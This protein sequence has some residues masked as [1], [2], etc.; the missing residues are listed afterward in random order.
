LH[1]ERTPENPIIMKHIHCSYHQIW[2]VFALLVI[3]LKINASGGTY[4]VLD[5]GAKPDGKSLNTEIIQDAIDKCSKNGGGMVVIPSGRYVTGTVVLK[6]N[7]CLRLEKGAIILGS[8]NPK[9][10]IRMKPAYIAYRTGTETRQLIYA[11]SQD[12]ISIEGEGTIDGQGA[13]FVPADMDGAGLTD[14]GITRPH[15]IQLIT[16]TN[17]KIE[18][19]FLTNSG[20]WMQHY[21][22]CDKLQVRGIRVKNFSNINN[23]GID[24]DG[25]HDVNISDCIIESADDGIC[26]KATSPRS[27]KNVVI[28]NCNVHSLSNAIKMGTET[29]GGFQNISITN[30][31]I[32]PVENNS[33]VYN[34]PDGSSAISL[35]IVDGGLL[36]NVNISN[37]SISE[38]VC[39][40][41][42]RLGNRARKY[43]PDAEV[44]PVGKIRNI[45]LSDIIAVSSHPT[46][47]SVVGI[48][49][50]DVENIVF[51]NVQLISKSK[52]TPED[53]KRVVP[54][55]NDYPTAGMHG[56][57]L[58]ASAFYVRHAKNIRFV[59]LQLIV[60]GE[61]VRPPFVLDDAKDVLIIHPNVLLPDT[62]VK[63]IQE[64]HCKNIRLIKN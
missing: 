22:A 51:D 19:V 8:T 23:D 46:T 34:D 40:I 37:I 48:P 41:F 42:I 29:T 57:I 11:E 53:A 63:L 44:P 61:N 47:S 20:A 31:S 32:S 13:A 49:G 45:T 59:N 21:L 62:T 4:N 18:G 24:I 15:L 16:C 56:D 38:T 1:K 43:K 10:Y 2:L 64:Q 35:M 9:D 27:C 7:V 39:P 14:A 6:N 3:S 58:P 36:E 50:Y 17:I 55:S 5:M 33:F 30:C 54:E 26:L 60:E 25:C 52:G 12:N 28:S